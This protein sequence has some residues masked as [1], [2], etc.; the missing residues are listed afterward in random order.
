MS[1]REGTPMRVNRPPGRASLRKTTRRFVSRARIH[2]VTGHAAEMAFFAVLTLVPA[3]IAVGAAIGASRPLLG[4]EAMIRTEDG[5]VGA[6]RT[7]MGPEM[8]N[9]VISPFVHAQLQQA[10]GGVAL[11]ALL[12][13]W[14]LAGRLIAATAHALDACYG[15]T[16]ARQSFV[17][18][19]IALGFALASV[20]LVTATVEMMVVGPLG[21]ANSGPASWLGLGD[22]YSIVWSIA[23]WPILLAVV[24]GFLL[25]LYRVCA[26][27]RQSF[28]DCLPGALLGA[29][30]WIIAAVGFRLSAP[31]G[32]HGATWLANGDPIVTIIGESVN[33]VVATVLW[34]YF[35]SLAILAGGELNATLQ[36]RH[37]RAAGEHSCVS[38]AQEAVRAARAAAPIRAARRGSRVAVPVP[39]PAAVATGPVYID[40]RL[41]RELAERDPAEV[42]NGADGD[43]A[44][45]SA[46][47]P[48]QPST[49]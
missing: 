5:I 42:R 14:W 25:C 19:M 4:Y 18:R 9:A 36:A 11:G 33:A 16:D 10:N 7:L 49:T 38:E 17:E 23:K 20:L 28:R 46:P 24:V 35:A 29:T 2:R 8:T 47:E 32:L 21:S 26:N 39:A 15:V 40:P 30:L 3:T 12:A 1:L 41:E 31:L 34:A 45:E 27:V 37:G 44:A 48:V 13:A 6:V 43:R 22:A